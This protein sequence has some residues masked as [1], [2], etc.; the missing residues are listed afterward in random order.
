MNVKIIALGR[1]KEKWLEQGFLEYQKR[2]SA[3]GTAELCELEPVALPQ[4]P[5]DAQIS[6]ALEK[7]AAKI[8]EKIPPR[9]FTITLC[10]EGKKLSSE[11]LSELMQNAALVGKSNIAFI[12]GSSFGLSPSV[13]QAADF[14]LSISDMTFPHQLARLMLIEQIYRAFSIQN[15]GKYHK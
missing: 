5:S 8:S 13:K 12:I 15:G 10:I 9:A 14:R 11:G 7:E 3:Y 4:N 1:L 6:A 2:I